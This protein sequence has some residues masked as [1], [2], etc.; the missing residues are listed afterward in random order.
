VPDRYALRLHTALASNS[1]GP[2]TATW[3]EAV[4]TSAGTIRA[5]RSTARSIASNARQ[6][7]VDIFNQPDGPSN[8]SNTATTVLV[9]PITLANDRLSAAGTIRDSGRRVAAGDV[10]QLRSYADTL[11]A[12]PAFKG[13]E[14][15]I[16][17]ERD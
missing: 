17:I 7:T 2:Y 6:N 8:G 12:T 9:S 16:E 5:V 14:A 11:G 1:G 4:V 3:D 15:T 10:L 13:L